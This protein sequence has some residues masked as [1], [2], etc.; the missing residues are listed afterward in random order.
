MRENGG[1]ECRN[2]SLGRVLI[3]SKTKE[4]S[5]YEVGPSHE[6]DLTRQSL[7]KCKAPI[8]RLFC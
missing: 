4:I 5:G 6:V 8:R 1:M 7:Q 2:D 3:F